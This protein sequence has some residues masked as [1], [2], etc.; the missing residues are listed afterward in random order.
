MGAF[1]VDFEVDGASS[2]GTVNKAD[3]VVILE[4]SYTTGSLCVRRGV[5]KVVGTLAL[6][7]GAT[8]FFAGSVQQPPIRSRQCKKERVRWFVEN[9]KICQFQWGIKY[10]WSDDS[11]R[12]SVISV[13]N[14]VFP[15]YSG[16][17]WSC[18]ST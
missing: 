1:T 2:E 7:A 15:R 16:N 17:L 11:K 8:A 12:S 18:T 14:R 3:N 5:A 13:R 9:R 10:M 4:T 6:L